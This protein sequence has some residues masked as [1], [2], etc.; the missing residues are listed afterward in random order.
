M[1]VVGVVRSSGDPKIKGPPAGMG[2]W[3]VPTPNSL[4]VRRQWLPQ[5]EG[6]RVVVGSGELHLHM[7]EPPSPTGP[8]AQRQAG[9]WVLMGREVN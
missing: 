3:V 2:V 1:T 8:S 6:A 7:E 5:R 4:G 9:L